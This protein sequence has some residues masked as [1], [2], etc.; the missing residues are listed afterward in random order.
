LRPKKKMPGRKFAIMS[1][2][3]NTGRKKLP[4]KGLVI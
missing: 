3:Q 1:W 4:K 2:S